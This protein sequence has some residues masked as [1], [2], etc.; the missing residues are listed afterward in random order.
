MSSRPS[1]DASR[2]DLSLTALAAIRTTGLDVRSLRKT[3]NGAISYTTV[4]HG[5]A[6]IGPHQHS[7]R[8]HYIVRIWDVSLT[9]ALASVRMIC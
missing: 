1:R 4:L 2:M 8:S 6:P 7:I 3:P 5:V 9:N